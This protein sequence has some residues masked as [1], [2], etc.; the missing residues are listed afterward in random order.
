MTVKSSL[1]V[2]E[3]RWGLDRRKTT[4]G[5]ERSLKGLGFDGE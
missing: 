3:G 5:L 1:L 2:A 4:Q